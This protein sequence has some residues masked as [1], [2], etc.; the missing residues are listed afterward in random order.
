MNH[1]LDFF[2][3]KKFGDRWDSEV[4]LFTPGNEIGL[5]SQ[6][7]PN[8][9]H[10]IKLATN[11]E[12]D[13]LLSMRKDVSKRKTC[14][15]DSTLLDFANCFKAKLRSIFLDDNNLKFCPVC[16]N[17]NMSVCATVQMNIFLEPGKELNLCSTTE[18][19]K[20]SVQCFYEKI[21][22]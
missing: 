4:Y 2:F 16:K 6:F 14:L 9:V 10:H 1:C 20:C 3:Q 15:P 5:A 22:Y 7:W 18:G 19:Q 13:A 8:P 17:L 11:R 12:I 21:R